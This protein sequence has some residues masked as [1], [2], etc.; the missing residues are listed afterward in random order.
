M[1]AAPP[2]RTRRSPSRSGRSRNA[3]A[4]KQALL[5]AAQE[6]FGQGGF[7]G[8]TIRDIS[9]RAGVDHALIARY[10]GSK[11]DLYI[12]ALVAEAHG[13]QPPSEFE[14]LEDMADSM[15]ARVDEHGLGPVMQA[16]IRSDTSDQIRQAAQ[17]HMERR[18]V[19]PM[20]ANM[21]LRGIDGGDLRSE[22]VVSALIGISLGRALGWFD[23]LKAVP[24]EHLVDLITALLSEVQP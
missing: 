7:E 19:D 2:A 11:A 21:A 24:K 15:V 20:V 16:L 10:Y 18:M 17:A 9:D 8:T 12:A 1:T 5:V 6:L 23:H 4:S 3:V 14:G 22:V 13:D